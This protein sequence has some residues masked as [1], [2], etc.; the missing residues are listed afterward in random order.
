MADGTPGY[1]IP[2]VTIYDRNFVELGDVTL[3]ERLLVKDMRNA[4]SGCE[5]VASAELD[6]GISAELDDP[7]TR[8]VV[9]FRDTTIFSGRRSRVSWDGPSH[10]PTATATFVG[11]WQILYDLLTYPTPATSLTS[12]SK[13]VDSYWT[14]TGPLES[15]CKA[16]INANRA[17]SA[18]PITV[19]TNGA[20][21][22]TVKLSTRMKPIADDLRPLLTA[23]NAGL[24][25]VQVGA[26]ILISYVPP[27]AYGGTMSDETETIGQD[28]QID[29]QDPTVTAVVAGGQGEGADRFFYQEL[30]A[31]AQG[32][33][34]GRREQ[35]LDA[36]DLETEADIR[37]R[38][39]VTLAE[40]GATLSAR[41]PLA[42]TEGF[43]CYGP[44]G[45]H[46]GTLVDIDLIGRQWMDTVNEITTTW[47]VDEG[48]TVVPV[49]GGL[50][51]IALRQD[52]ARI[53]AIQQRIRRLETR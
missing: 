1:D 10:A 23:Q 26:G 14:F 39:I 25:V 22:T 24:T 2:R 4:P 31:V 43:R 41:I 19:E 49:A 51:S 18:I 12:A 3:P 28:W 37:A 35:F 52:R 46:P 36:R 34:R 33:V 32:V 45:V 16:L 8:C 38:A 11:D 5:V 21:G 30:D 7:G 50:E 9:T 27:E 53:A 29:E 40:A 17:R 42:E 6:T 20:R 47:T 48:L 44:G 15:A 13:F